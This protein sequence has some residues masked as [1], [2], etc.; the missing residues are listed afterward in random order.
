VYGTSGP[1]VDSL[2]RR[3]TWPA[4][5]NPQDEPY[6]PTPIFEPVDGHCRFCG[7]KLW[8][9]KRVRKADFCNDSHQAAYERRQNEL[10]LARL[11]QAESRIAEKPD[12]SGG[13]GQPGKRATAA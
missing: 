4:I 13:N 5:S 7:K 10:A 3:R 12:W 9:L 6:H 2:P 11:Y 8:F 1:D